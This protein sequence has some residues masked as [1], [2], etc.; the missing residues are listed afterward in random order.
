MLA[1]DAAK[2]ITGTYIGQWELFGL[3]PVGE[4]IT[5]SRWTGGSPPDHRKKGCWSW[6]RIL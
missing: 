4:I 5:K 3:S 6:P 2:D 1:V